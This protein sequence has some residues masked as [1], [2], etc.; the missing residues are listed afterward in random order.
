MKWKLQVGCWLLPLLAACASD[1]REEWFTR[2]TY[3][4]TSQLELL[5]HWPERRS[6]VEI[7]AMISSADQASLARVMERA[8]RAGANAVLLGPEYRP[9][10]ATSTGAGG[11]GGRLVTEPYAAPLVRVRAV[12][13]RYLP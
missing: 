12:L 8:M 2:Q 4:P 6:F 7:G 5:D 3:P 1:A 11:A 10:A 9:E 13:I